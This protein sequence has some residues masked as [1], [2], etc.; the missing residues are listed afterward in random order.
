MRGTQPVAS[1]SLDLD[2]KWTY[3]RSHGD[4]RW[5]SFPSYL[6]LVVPRALRLLKEHGLK[7]TVF[8]VG[9]DAALAR[10]HELLASI[11]R[12]GHEIANHSFHHDLTLHL[13]SENH[14]DQELA[15]M[16][17]SAFNIIG[18]RPV[19]FRGPG[20]GV[21]SAT[22]RV[23]ARRGYEY[24][25]S[26][27]PA[28][29]GPLLRAYHFRMSR[30]SPAERRARRAT[31]PSLKDCLRPLEPHLWTV[32][33]ERVL[34]IPVTTVPLL[35]LPFQFSY[36]LYLCESAPSLARQYL[37]GALWLC[38]RTGVTPSLL[39][40]PP[41][42]LGRDD[43]VDLAFYPGMRL[44]TETKLQWLD[45]A[46]RFVMKLFTVVPI[47]DH[48]RRARTSTRTSLDAPTV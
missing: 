9:H 16:E 40:H 20:F 8:V 44:E 39:L 1:L 35:R 24:D 6:H 27:F 23:L 42:F 18:C 36:L 4:V 25:A 29:I 34:E 38:R 43:D 46:L 22:L 48:A 33:G 2:D 31:F 28:S 3:L 37:R 15:R 45:S 17:E 10:N 5:K 14:I 7:I 26:S 12:A 30:L 19:G 32:D 47:R 13:Q 11:P 21:S 41:D